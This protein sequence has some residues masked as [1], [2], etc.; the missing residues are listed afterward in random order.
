M[1]HH[2]NKMKMLSRYGT[3]KAIQTLSHP[4]NF[5]ESRQKHFSYC[6]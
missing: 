6:Q 1:Y 4:Y 5:L 2:S 3:V